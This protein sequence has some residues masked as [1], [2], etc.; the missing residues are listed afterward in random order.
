MEVGS[1][2]KRTKLPPPELIYPP[3]TQEIRFSEPEEIH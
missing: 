1:P 2:G 3:P